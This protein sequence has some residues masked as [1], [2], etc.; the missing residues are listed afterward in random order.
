MNCEALSMWLDLMRVEGDGIKQQVGM[1][2]WFKA[3]KGIATNDK[4]IHYCFL[5][6][7]SGELLEFNCRRDTD[8]LM[9]ENKFY[10]E[11]LLNAI[12]KYYGTENNKV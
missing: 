8:S 3:R 9:T 5:D 1:Q 10:P 6:T 2:V 7:E 12:F 4:Y 11:Y